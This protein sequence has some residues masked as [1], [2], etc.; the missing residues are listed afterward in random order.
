VTFLYKFQSIN[1]NSLSALI[2]QSLYFASPNELND[3]TEGLFDLTGFDGESDYSALYHS[4]SILSVGMNDNK[5]P[6]SESLFHWTHYGNGLKGMCLVFKKDGLIDNFIDDVET[7][8]DVTYGY[9]IS[10]DEPCDGFDGCEVV[11]GVDVEK[12]KIKNFISYAFNN[13]PKCFS[14]ESEYRFVKASKNSK[15]F[16]CSKGLL[17]YGLSSLDSIIIGDKIGDSDW[18][19]L[20]SVL[21]PISSQVTLKKAKV[22]NGSF[23]IYVETTNLDDFR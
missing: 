15:T 1:N 16:E 14:I 12:I 7:Y 21:R 4:C 13:K 20:K 11:A 8:E 9:P 5:S 6:L 10:I 17:K 19:I 22:K 23:S 3:P 18:E 2:K